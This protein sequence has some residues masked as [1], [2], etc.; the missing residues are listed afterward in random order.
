MCSDKHYADTWF[1]VA[2]ED[3]RLSEEHLAG[4]MLSKRTAATL[5][6][7][8]EKR[9]QRMM[10]ASASS[11]TASLSPSGRDLPIGVQLGNAASAG[12]I[13]F[14]GRTFKSTDTRVTSK[15]VED[16]VKLS[17]LASRAGLGDLVWYSWESGS[18][19]QHPGHGT[20][21]VGWSQKAARIVSEL[22]KE[23]AM[24]HFDLV[25]VRLL[26]E[27]STPLSASYVFPP[28]GHFAEHIS[29]CE[30]SDGWVRTATWK[31]DILQ[32]TEAPPGVKVWLGEFLKKGVKWTKE[33]P[34]LS[35]VSNW[36][37]AWDEAAA[38]HIDEERREA[39]S[40]RSKRA[41]RVFDNHLK[42]R[43]WA[44]PGEP[45]HG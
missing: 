37:S 23:E 31:K 34:S 26:M 45:A 33:L 8:I 11:S 20:T 42:H 15:H 36:T 41:M 32:S 18:R 25:L 43:E 10:N 39:G 4:H 1:I 35:T 22:I 12:D 13:E 14:L 30:G 24:D 17:I 21:L 5:D 40:Q 3:W 19:K 9:T 27:P 2:E 29:G 7:G 38:S 44:L 6:E 28:I 16:L